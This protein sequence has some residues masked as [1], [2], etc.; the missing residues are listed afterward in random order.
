LHLYVKVA[1]IW[2]PGIHP[3]RPVLGSLAGL[4][5]AAT[6]GDIEACT[7][8]CKPYSMGWSLRVWSENDEHRAVARQQDGAVRR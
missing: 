6:S 1:S 3:K 2:Y 5:A 7:Y 4:R 8:K